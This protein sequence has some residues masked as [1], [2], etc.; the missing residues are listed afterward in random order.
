MPDKHLDIYLLRCLQAFV[1][2]AHV[3]KAAERMGT[4]QPAMSS[5]LR[6]LREIFNDPL[7]VRTEKGMVPTERARELADSLRGAI[8]IIDTALAVDQPFDP[9]SATM[10]F[11]IAASESVT[12]ML[13]PHLIA[14][15]RQ[16]APGIQLRVRIPD[17]QRARQALEEGEIDL[18]LSFTRTAPGGLRSSALWTQK[19]KVIAAAAHAVDA[20][21]TLADYLRWPHACHKLGRSG[22]SIEVAVD[23]V[24]QQMHRERTVGVWL[25]SA[26][27]VPAV[28]ARTDFLATVP[29][30]VATMFAPLLGLKTLPPPLPL[31]DVQIGMYWHERMQKNP[32]HRWLRELL[33]T[34]AGDLMGVGADSASATGQAP[35]A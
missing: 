35:A 10:A 18:L 22:S 15:V 34:V 23:A 21:L 32:P 19:L 27:S 33:R 5:V 8:D 26:I 14:R 4:T 30:E 1:E 9:G 28:V 11:E 12:F 7:L 16:L 25:P 24:L 17:L 2:E 31:D 3:T 29:E 20:G 13:V 6:R